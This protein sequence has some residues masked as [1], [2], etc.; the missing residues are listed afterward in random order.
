MRSQ[1]EGEENGVPE[2]TSATRVG[3]LPRLVEVGFGGPIEESSGSFRLVLCPIADGESAPTA[4]T[5]FCP[6]ADR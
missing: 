6:R 2:L 5:Q 4:Q 1:F 3:Q